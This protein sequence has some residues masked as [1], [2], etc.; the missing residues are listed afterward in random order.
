MLKA[1][2]PV[3]LDQSGAALRG[4]NPKYLSLRF[5][6]PEPRRSPAISSVIYQLS[7]TAQWIQVVR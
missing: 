5:M 1:G 3:P 4:T 6:C 2:V 7:T